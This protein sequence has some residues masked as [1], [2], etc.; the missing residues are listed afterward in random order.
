MKHN[1]TIHYRNLPV[2][3]PWNLLIIALLLDR[4]SAPEWAWGA[5]LFLALLGCISVV[6]RLIS[7]ENVDI[8]KDGK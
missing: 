1:K 8:F 6:S 3:M 7:E 2:R 5:F 4:S